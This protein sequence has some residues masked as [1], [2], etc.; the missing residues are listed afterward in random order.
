M[1]GAR[2]RFEGAIAGIGTASGTRVVLGHW[3]RSPFGAFNDVMLERAD[4]QRTL[5][6]PT[7]QTADFIAATYT[8]DHVH[9]TP[10][11]VTTGAEWCVE[12]AQ[13]RLRLTPGPR[14]PLGLLLHTVPHKLAARPAWITCVDVPA[15]LLPG[16][17]ARGSAGR[18]R[19]EWYGVH[20]LHPV[21]SA[22]GQLA[23][24][25]LGPLAPVEPPVRF[26]FS[27]VPRRPSLARVTT[28]V[29]LGPPG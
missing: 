15:R 17:R 16:V 5:L 21:T 12:A 27:S 22:T 6:A 11:A 7:R 24:E 20:D 29:E 2:V 8:F 10:V 9:V 3:T 1:K 23:G 18:G 28:T 13:L 19:R 14:G 4:G 26:G 25:H